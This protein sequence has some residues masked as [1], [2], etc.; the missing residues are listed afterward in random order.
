[1]NNKPVRREWLGRQEFKGELLHALRLLSLDDRLEVA[2][3]ALMLAKPKGDTDI[4]V[5]PFRERYLILH[6]R[7]KLPAD[8]VAARLGWWYGNGHPPRGDGTRLKR[9]LGLEAD[10]SGRGHVHVARFVTY[11][12]ASDLCRALDIDPVDVGV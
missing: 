11:D 7:D 12:V 9:R 8:E 10:K 3:G 5:T 2:L 4:D 1:V 6:A